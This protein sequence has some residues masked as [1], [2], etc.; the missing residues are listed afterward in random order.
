MQAPV[1]DA[2]Y[3]KE[4]EAARRAIRGLIVEKQCAPLLLRLS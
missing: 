2:G 4:V 3:L 1:V